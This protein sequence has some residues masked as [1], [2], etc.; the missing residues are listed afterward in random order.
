MKNKKLIEN[1]NGAERKDKFKF[2]IKLIAKIG[3]I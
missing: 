2:V 1:S 3:Q